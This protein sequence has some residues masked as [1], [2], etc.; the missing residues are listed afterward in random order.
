MEV[1]NPLH[2]YGIMKRIELLTC[3]IAISFSAS[4]IYAEAATAYNPY[5]PNTSWQ[6]LRPPPPGS[7]PIP[8]PEMPG[9]LGA[10]NPLPSG[11]ADPTNGTGL[12]TRAAMNKP[13]VDTDPQPVHNQND[14][15]PTESFADPQPA[16]SQNDP[17]PAE[18]RNDPQP[19]ENMSDPQP[20]SKTVDTGVGTH[21]PS[22]LF[23]IGMTGD[24]P[25]PLPIV[26]W[27]ARYLVILGV[28]VATIY[29]AFAAYSLVNGNRNGPARVALAAGGLM[30]LLCAF[31]IWKI[32]IINAFNA[33]TAN[34][35]TY[36]YSADVDNSVEGNTNKDTN[37]YGVAPTDNSV[38][39]NPQQNTGAA[40]VPPQNLGAVTTRRAS[41]LVPLTN[42]ANTPITPAYQPSIPPRSPLLVQPLNGQ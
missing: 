14:P 17:Q 2:E 9:D 30:M 33:I 13:R 15:Q 12:P 29:M 41:N 10:Q 5:P 27:F 34:K 22:P 20:V 8:A 11:M 26:R 31:T 4:V 36:S 23:D 38:E 32:I 16:S 1:D 7:G 25:G 18:S 19:E 35:S 6:I 37:A 3:G 21:P 28:V 24:L 40:G 39:G 42:R